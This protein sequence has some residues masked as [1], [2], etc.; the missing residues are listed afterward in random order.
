M[1]AERSSWADAWLGTTRELDEDELRDAIAIDCEMVLCSKASVLAHVCAVSC[2]DEA[3]LLNSHCA[4]PS[5]VTDYLTRYSGV[6]PADLEGAPS[7]DE[8][9]RRVAALVEGRLV[10]GHGLQNDLKALGL[11]DHPPSL[12]FD[13]LIDLDWGAGRRRGLAALSLELLGQ[14]IQRLVHSPQE[15]AIATIRLLRLHRRHCGPPPPLRISLRVAT[16]SRPQLPD[17]F[18]V[19]AAT[20]ELDA[21]ADAEASVADEWSIDFEWSSGCVMSLLSWW[22]NVEDAVPSHAGGGLR[23]QPTLPTEHRKALHQ[24]AKRCSVKTSSAGLGALRAIRVLPPGEVA[25]V[26]AELTRRIAHLAWKLSRSAV[27]HLGPFAKGAPFSQ[28]EF[29]EMVDGLAAGKP[30]PDGV[31]QLLACARSALSSLPYPPTRDGEDA[32]RCSCSAYE[33]VLLVQGRSSTGGVDVKPRSGRDSGR[34]RRR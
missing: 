16:R 34:R 22:A 13:T 28:G 12:Q 7:F 30:P 31:A 9:K 2:A 17:G 24:A 18:G 29:E 32:A 15:D 4:P 1:A 3:V 11:C 6:R 23:F 8:V 33:R 5:P 25:P 21:D 26:P 10:V 27:E 20:Q 14:P 19:L